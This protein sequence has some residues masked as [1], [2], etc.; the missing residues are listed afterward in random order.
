MA[1]RG[2]R[3][4]RQPE[5]LARRTGS[6]W[7]TVALPGRALYYPDEAVVL[8]PADAWVAD[9]QQPCTGSGAA[10]VCPTTLYRWDG[11]SW[12]PFTLPLTARES[13]ELSA[14][15]PTNVWVAGASNACL[16]SR[17]S[18]TPA[19]Y[20]WNGSAWLKAPALPLAHSYYPPDVV[21]GGKRV[22][23]G[24]VAGPR[25]G[26]ASQA[27]SCT[28]TAAAGRSSTLP[29][30]SSRRA[31]WSPTGPAGRGWA[32]MPTGPAP[33]G[34]TSEPLSPA[35]CG[36]AD[37]TRIPGTAML[38]GGGVCA[39]VRAPLRQRHLRLPQSPLSVMSLRVWSASPRAMAATRPAWIWCRRLISCA[40]EVFA[41]WF[42]V[43]VAPAIRDLRLWAGGIGGGS[44]AL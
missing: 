44:P 26:L 32:P 19:A 10:E 20:H 31:R 34:S 11:S 13:T 42:E 41:A 4:R 23:C 6:Q 40:A 43:F 2:L 7:A 25:P 9:P 16:A 29:M 8:S 33:G 28:G 39:A 38:W 1:V 12:S 17:C 24:S 27:A 37:V 30:I 21:A 36:M 35:T 3:K 5:G 14:S 15:S 22:T 18:Y